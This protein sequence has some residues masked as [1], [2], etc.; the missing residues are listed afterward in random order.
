M[1]VCGRG[2]GR[3]GRAS[4]ASGRNERAGGK[5]TCAARE[6][7]GVLSRRR[8]KTGTTT[9]SNTSAPSLP[10]LTVLLTT[11]ML[12]TAAS[13]TSGAESASSFTKDFHSPVSYTHLTLPTI[14]SV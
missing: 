11:L 7:S 2:R 14:C 3:D 4:Q 8:L 5:S 9:T 12:P 13:R 1:C 10:D 6:T